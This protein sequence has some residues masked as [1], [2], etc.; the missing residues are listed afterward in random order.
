M[1][2]ISKHKSVKLTQTVSG[3]REILREHTNKINEIVDW[4]NNVERESLMQQFMKENPTV[5]D[6]DIPNKF[7]EWIGERMGNN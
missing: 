7:D 6:D 3:Q 4:I 2:K 5:L 1:K